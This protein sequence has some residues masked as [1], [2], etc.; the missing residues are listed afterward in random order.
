M[1]NFHK[2]GWAN[3]NDSTLLVISREDNGSIFQFKKI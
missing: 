3:S 1:Y 2:V